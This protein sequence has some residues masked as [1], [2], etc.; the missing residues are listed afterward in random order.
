MNRILK[1]IASWKLIAP[2][3][4]AIMVTW[5]MV[6]SVIFVSH[7]RASGKVVQLIQSGSGD[8]A[9]Y[10]PVTVFHDAAGV[11]HKIQSSGGSNPPRFPVG[12][13]V[14]VLYRTD[15]PDAGMIEDH[16]LM[17]IVP[18]VFIALGIFYG[19]IG[20]VV[21]RWLQKKGTRNAA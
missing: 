21:D 8:E 14:S 3:L 6:S 11:E 1:S 10:I 12:S 19:S 20:I 2:A 15:N 16:V 18:L 13:T 4:I 9:I 5:L 7:A 17:W